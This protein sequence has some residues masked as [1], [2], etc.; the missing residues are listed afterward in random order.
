MMRLRH[1]SSTGLGNVYIYLIIYIYIPR[2][3]N[4][5]FLEVWLDPKKDLKHRSPQEVFGRLGYIYI[6]TYS[7]GSMYGIF[8][9]IYH[10]FKPNGGKYTIHG[11]YGYTCI[12]HPP[13]HFLYRI[14]EL[15]LRFRM[16]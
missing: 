13:D 10:N 8:T 1:T 9:Y 11:A 12:F 5:L 14:G 2:L 7:I 6:Y 3:P 16:T 15:E 4:T